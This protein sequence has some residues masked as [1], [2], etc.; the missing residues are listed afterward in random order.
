MRLFS[1]LSVIFVIILFSCNGQ[2]DLI[3][4]GK[5]EYIYKKS[6]FFLE[7]QREQIIFN[8]DSTFILSSYTGSVCEGIWKYITKDTILIKCHDEEQNMFE[9]LKKTYLYPREI[10]MK[11]LNKNKI[12][13]PLHDRNGK[14]QKNVT[15]KRINEINFID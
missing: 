15:L 12:K 4:N 14:F 10:K 11:I 9:K 2:K 6:P 5:Y 7:E 3:V 1:S 13:M 8:A